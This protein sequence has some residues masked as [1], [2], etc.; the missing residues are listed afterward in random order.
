MQFKVVCTRLQGE[1]S[2]RILRWQ[3]NENGVKAES[4]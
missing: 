1:E 4:L 3:V 2:W